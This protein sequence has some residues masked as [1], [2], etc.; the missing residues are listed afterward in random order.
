MEENSRKVQVVIVGG[1]Q[2]GLAVGYYLRRS[3]LSFV[4]LDEQ[5][6]S[7]GAWLHGWESLRLFS[8]AEHSSLPGWLMP[9]SEDEYPP[10]KQ[11]INYL[12][13]YEKRYNLPVVRPV[14]VLK[15][16]FTDSRYTLYTSDGQWQADAV[17]SATGSWSN[18]YIPDYPGKNLFQGRQLHS[19][20]YHTPDELKGQKVLI[21]GGGNSGAQILAE[22][23]KVAETVWVTEREPTFLSDEV[24]GR[25][26]FEFASRQYKAKLEGKTIEPIGGLGDV[27][28]VATVKEARERN[29]LQSLRPFISFTEQGVVWPDGRKENFDS[30][31]WCTGFKPSLDYLQELH[32][33]EA[34]GKVAVNGT[35]ATKTPRLWLVGFGTWTGYASAT[36]IGVGRTARSTAEEIIKELNIKV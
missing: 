30:V 15:V 28:M 33:I 6:R 35:K 32:I 10:V 11:V 13:A 27:V 19:A 29:V 7:G 21:V 2:S 3:G 12:D 24:D 23:S 26:L 4:I 34:D 9:R 16:A 8:P 31:I 14:K 1:G 36:L 5:P 25:Y 20:N 18:P 22:V 17:V